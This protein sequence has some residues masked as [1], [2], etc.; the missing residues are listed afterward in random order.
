M[1]NPVKT[2][3]LID[4]NEAV[5]MT[6]RGIMRSID[7][8]VLA[9]A[10]NGGPALDIIKRT[11]PDLVCLD[12]VMPGKSGMDVLKEIR[13]VYPDLPVLMITGMSTREII[14]ELLVAGATGIVVKPFSPQKVIQ[15]ACRVLGI[16]DHARNV[17]PFE[18]HLDI[19]I[20]DTK[21]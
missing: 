16:Q 13:E 17:D 3:V 20:A 18:Q 11:E 19:K 14:Q 4:D 12:V 21:P 5:R 2:V 9:E 1:K 8:E 7:F 6:L 10:N 15:T